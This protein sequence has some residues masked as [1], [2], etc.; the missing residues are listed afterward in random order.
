M[1]ELGTSLEIVDVGGGLGIPYADDEAPLDL[2]R[3]RTGLDELAADPAVGPTEVVIEPGRFLVGPAGSLVTRVIDAKR[4][5]GRAIAIVDAGINTLLRPV[6]VGQGQRIRRWSLAHPGA[7]NNGPEVGERVTIAG[8]LCTGL[9]VLGADLPLGLPEVG[10]LLTIADAGAY[11]FTESMP[12]FL[13]RPIAAEVI[14]DSRAT[15]EVAA[16]TTAD[17]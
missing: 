6:L 5:R 12:F 15:S 7:P 13:S 14:V 8:P 10:E 2:A 1:I 16:G 3:L 4:V 11:G 9:D 17:R